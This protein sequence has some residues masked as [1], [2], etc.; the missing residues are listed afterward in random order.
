[1][2]ITDVSLIS[3]TKIIKF[4]NADTTGLTSTANSE[5]VASTVGT[6]ALINQIISDLSS[7]KASIK[8]E[9]KKITEAIN[10]LT[11]NTI[12]GNTNLALIKFGSNDG[13]TT[14]LATKYLSNNG[15]ETGSITDRGQIPTATS[16]FAVLTN[17]TNKLTETAVASI[18]SDVYV[19]VAK[20]KNGAIAGIDCATLVTSHTS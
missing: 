9:E 15:F 16:N 7:I 6:Y 14:T 5:A 17:G 2:G 1:M 10:N 11:D 13:G 19:M 20:L 18:L 8:V 12:G 3:S 4:L